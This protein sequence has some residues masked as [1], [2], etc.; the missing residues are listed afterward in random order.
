MSLERKRAYS[1]ACE[2]PETTL[3]AVCAESL[4]LRTSVGFEYSLF[5]AKSPTC[6]ETCGIGTQAV[7]RE[8]GSRLGDD[9][10]TIFPPRATS[11][12]AR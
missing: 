6:P 5:M 1:G 12:P 11:L 9:Y 3:A 2:S 10:A 4:P 7:K 8:A